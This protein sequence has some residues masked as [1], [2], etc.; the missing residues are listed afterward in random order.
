MAE[1]SKRTINAGMQKQLVRGGQACRL[2]V[3]G[4]NGP[5]QKL[6]K[7]ERRAIDTGSRALL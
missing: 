5:P 2:C 4:L 1:S 6:K 3:P 7:R